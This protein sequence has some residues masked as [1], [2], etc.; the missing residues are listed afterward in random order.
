MTTIPSTIDVIGRK[1][2]VEYDDSLK[3]LLGV[4]DSDG[5]KISILPG[6]VK[7][8]ELDTLLHEVVHAIE[9]AML[10]NMT[11]RQVYCVTV[12]LLAVLKNNPHFLEYLNKAI[13]NE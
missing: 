13:N 4:C 9:I 12:G 2:Q 6:Q 7:A 5:L 1:Y 10:L 3:G 8:M 11:E